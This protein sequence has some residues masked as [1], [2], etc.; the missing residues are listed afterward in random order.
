[1]PYTTNNK[2]HL[3]NNKQQI[4]MK[5]QK[6]FQYWAFLNGVA[7]KV[8]TEW[9]DYSGPEYPIQQK[10]YKGNHLKNEFRTI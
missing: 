9:F 1:M 6:R 8:W 7:R 4:T 5:R 10:G 3:T 2:Q